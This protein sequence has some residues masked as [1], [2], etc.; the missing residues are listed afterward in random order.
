MYYF[1]FFVAVILKSC[2]YESIVLVKVKGKIH[3]ETG[4]EG[5]ER[6]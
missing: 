3:P 5:P 4:H 6:E 1:N 2:Q